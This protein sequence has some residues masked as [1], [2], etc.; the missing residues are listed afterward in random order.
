MAGYLVG[1]LAGASYFCITDYIPMGYPASP[2][3][4]M[5][6]GIE[7]FWEGIGGVGGWEVGSAEGGWG[8]GWILLDPQSNGQAASSS[9]SL[10]H[11]KDE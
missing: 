5:R 4:R 7:W 11:T 10:D 3:G 1:L 2:P 9:S 6:A 8:E